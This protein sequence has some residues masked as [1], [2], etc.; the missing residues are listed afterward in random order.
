[1]HCDIVLEDVLPK[2]SLVI[3][4]ALNHSSGT[5]AEAEPSSWDSRLC[6]GG[7]QR[8]LKPC[9]SPGCFLGC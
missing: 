2:D 9:L 5:G 6:P 8:S 4:A 1:M 3:F 7:L